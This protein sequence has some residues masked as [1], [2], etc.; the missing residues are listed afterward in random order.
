MEAKVRVAYIGIGKMGAAMSTRLLQAG[1]HL[2]VYN[3]TIEKVKSLQALGATAASSL[4]EAIEDIDVVF[5][6]LTNDDAVL[7]VS[8]ELLKHAKQGM[9]HISTSTI[10]PKTAKMLETL[11]RNAGSIYLA[12]PV[13]GIPSAVKTKTA[14]TICAGNQ[15][16]IKQIMHLLETYSLRIENMG[17]EVSHANVFKIGMNYSLIA[18]IELISELYVFVEKSGV[19]KAYIQEALRHI[20][21]HPA[22]HTYID[23][24]YHRDFNQ[25]NFDMKDGMKDIQLFKKA[26]LEANVTPDIATIL[27]GKFSEALATKMEHQDWSAVSEVVRRRSGLD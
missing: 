1:H 19:D 7:S 20:Y 5:T 17:E 21:A 6:S 24:I 16:A 12:S 3:R 22:I 10:L 26:F 23:K 27:E 8:I 2:M 18:A 13:L 11:H 9:I 4:Q 14:T 25:V 15:Q